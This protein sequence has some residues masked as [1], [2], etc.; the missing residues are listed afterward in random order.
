[1]PFQNLE[2]GDDILVVPQFSGA[3]HR[4][5]SEQLRDN[6]VH[7]FGEEDVVIEIVFERVF[8]DLKDVFHLRR[9]FWSILRPTLGEQVVFHKRF[10]VCIDGGTERQVLRCTR[11]MFDNL[12]IDIIFGG[13]GL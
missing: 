5:M 7:V 1:M 13:H 6:N 12:R 9:F 8:Y 4:R 11:S 2:C 3:Q 10:E